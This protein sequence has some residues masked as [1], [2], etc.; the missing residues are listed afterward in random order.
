MKAVG[1]DFLPP[2]AY[3]EVSKATPLVPH[4]GGMLAIGEV[5]MTN[6]AAAADL[7]FGYKQPNAMW[8]AGS[9]TAASTPDYLDDTTDAQ[10]AAAGDFPLFTLVNNGGFLVQSVEKFNMIGI[11][12]S[13]AAS[14]GAPVYAYQY[15]NGTSMVALTPRL[16]GTFSATGDTI[17]G[18][19]APTDWVKGSTAAVG[20]DS[21]KY[22]LQVISTTASTTAGGTASLLWVGSWL[23]YQP[24]VATNNSFSFDIPNYEAVLLGGGSFLPYFG[25]ANAANT[26]QAHYRTI[27]SLSPV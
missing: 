16:S 9:I 18:F 25:L 17:I 7:A 4:T 27:G 10:S 8:K 1:Y 14:G 13:T 20:A 26:V 2:T 5:T 23:A 6:M 19:L 22:C 3:P 15:Y 11:T 12:I 21:D 24:Q